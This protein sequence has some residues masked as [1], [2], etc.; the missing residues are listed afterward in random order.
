MTPRPRRGFTL[1]ELLVVISIIGVL[2]GLL[3][4]AINAAREAGRRTQCSNNMRQL[5]L[6]L[7]AFAGRKNVYPAAGTFFEDPVN[8]TSAA[9]SIPF[10][11]QGS[12][13][14]GPA[15]TVIP[16]AGYSWVVSILSDLDQADLANAW[17][18]QQTYLNTGP[19]SGDSTAAPNYT[20]SH[21]SLGVLRC[22]DDNNYS[23][24]EGNLS[25]VVN[26][27]F[28]RYS[29]YPLAWYGFQSDGNPTKGGSQTVNVNWDSGTTISY[30]TPAVDQKAGVMFLNSFYNPLDTTLASTG[31]A[32]NSQPKWGQDK[33]NLSAITDGTS[34]T[35]LL[36][37]STLVGYSSGT[38]FSGGA[39]TNWACPLPNFCMFIASDNICDANGGGIPPTTPT[40]TCYAATAFNGPTGSGAATDNPAWHYANAQGTYE[41]INY[42]QVLTLKGS[43]PFATSGH[44][45]GANF[46]F[47][48]G[49]V[50]FIS[51]TIDG[52]V[53]S[54]IITPA[55][56]K[57]PVPYKQLPVSQD[58]FAP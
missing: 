20:I 36:G 34:S 53:Y 22:P 35:L 56:S 15:A 48:D 16:R 17:S 58:S 54:K 47:C 3:L 2:V 14:T 51:N 11:S 19:N 18:Q 26:G 6:A 30:V 28:V 39:E 40:G 31:I 1:I 29:Q 42:G 44:P 27:G 50:R 5:V 46:G 43:F 55:G 25:Y 4:P 21:S 37:E 32:P 10:Q 57:L 45:T 7:N 8:S 52:T 23:A 41:N 12:G 24:N 9:N 13:L 33:T 49:A 38:P